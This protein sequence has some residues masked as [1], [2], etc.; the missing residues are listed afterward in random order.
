MEQPMPWKQT[1]NTAP[2][3][4]GAGKSPSTQAEDF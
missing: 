1:I 4:R 2:A 3:D